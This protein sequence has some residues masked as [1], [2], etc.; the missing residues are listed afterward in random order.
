MAHRIFKGVVD[1]YTIIIHAN[2]YRVHWIVQ[3]SESELSDTM[4]SNVGV[5]GVCGDDDYDDDVVVSSGAYLSLGTQPCCCN[6]VKL[7]SCLLLLF[8]LRWKIW[9]WFWKHAKVGS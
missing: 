3:L 7:V 2:E 8:V 5:F 4:L 1:V 6:N 9:I